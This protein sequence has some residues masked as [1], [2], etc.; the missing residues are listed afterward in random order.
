MPLDELDRRIESWF[1]RQWN[2]PLDFEVD[3]GVRKLRELALATEDAD[4]RLTAVPLDKALMRKVGYN[5]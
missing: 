4:G 2:Q 1:V 3:D 5:A